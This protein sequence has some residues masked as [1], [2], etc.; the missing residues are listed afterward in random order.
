[1]DP[2]FLCPECYDHFRKLQ[3]KVIRNM[4]FGVTQT[5]V[6]ATPVA[7]WCC[8]LFQATFSFPYWDSSRVSFPPLCQFHTVQAEKSQC[9]SV[10]HRPL[11]SQALTLSGSAWSLKRRR[12]LQPPRSSR[13]ARR[14]P[15]NALSSPLLLQDADELGCCTSSVPNSSSPSP[16]FLILLLFF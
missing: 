9:V 6:R 1:M 8:G 12:R 15:W 16:S 5:L 7:F 10:R 3:D 2:L 11:D 4:G 13:P 14:L